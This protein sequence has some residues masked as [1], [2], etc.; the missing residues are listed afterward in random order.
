MSWG[1]TSTD[2]G[3]ARSIAIDAFLEGNMAL[4]QSILKEAR[5]QLTKPQAEKIVTRASGS[6]ALR[7]RDRRASPVGLQRG[8]ARG[9][10]GWARDGDR[11]EAVETPM[12][13]PPT[14]RWSSTHPTCGAGSRR[15][16]VMKKLAT[17]ESRSSG[18]RDRKPK[19]VTASSI[20]GSTSHRGT[21]SRSWQT[22][23]RSRC[24]RDSRNASC[25]RGACLP[26]SP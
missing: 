22:R 25:P 24:S 4:G 17:R 21:T 10:V 11:R 1:R 19:K 20:S 2:E 23:C 18:A 26:H 13:C 3:A 5:T 7:R 6:G 15:T 16:E 8:G 14:T 12:R 9:P